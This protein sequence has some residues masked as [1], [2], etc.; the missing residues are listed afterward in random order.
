MNF[1]EIGITHLRY[2]RWATAQVLEECAPLASEL[3]LKNLGG[4]F[5]SIHDTLVHLYRADSVWLDRLHDRPTDKLEK[6][7]A[8]GC[9]F[10]LRDAWTQ[11]Q[12]D[13]I[14]R[15]RQLTE[16]AWERVLSYR[17]QAGLPYNSPVWQVIMHVVNHGTYHRGQITNML[18]QLDMKPVNLDLIRFYRDLSPAPA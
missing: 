17:T 1:P 8:P 2:H 7:T 13:M 6:Y 3:L 9:M 16:P 10:E 14:D 5:P 15:A 4:S 18:R 11:V 12:E